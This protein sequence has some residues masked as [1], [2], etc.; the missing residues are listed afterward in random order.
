MK[1]IFVLLIVAALVAAG[2]WFGRSKKGLPVNEDRSIAD[3]YIA[4]VEKR[5]ID[6]SIEVSGDVTPEF[7]LDVRPEVG[8]KVNKL[9]AKPGHRVNRGDLLVEIDD[10]DLL[11][12]K[13]ATQTESEGAKL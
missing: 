9:Q 6:F 11:N 10:T 1:K 5:D 3:K 2:A 12:E 7:Q 4:K 13:A 8:G